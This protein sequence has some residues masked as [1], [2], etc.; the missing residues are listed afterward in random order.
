MAI[1]ESLRLGY[2]C[3]NTVLRE[4]DIFSS[5]GIRLENV[6]KKGVEELQRLSL[7]NIEDTK[8]I[9]RWN[10]LNGIRSFRL[11]SVLLP[12]FTNPRTGLH[13]TMDF[14]KPK[15]RELGD[16]ARQFG[17]RITMHPDHFSYTIVS[18][19][20]EVVRHAIADLNMHAEI[21][22]A[23]GMGPDSVMCIHGPGTQDDRDRVLEEWGQAVKALPETTRRRLVLENTE[24][25]YD[26]LT[27]LKT[28]EKNDIPHGTRLVP[29]PSSRCKNRDNR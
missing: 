27:V 4:D 13:M 22:D 12:H 21:L 16:L 6:T 26:V 5:R 24:H 19:N 9:V 3:I 10:E 2:A 1:H 17:H 15:L 25:N 7:E 29:Q 14:A 23:M 18:K 28:C 8:T 20:P 11:T